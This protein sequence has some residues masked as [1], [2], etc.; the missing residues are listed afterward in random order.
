MDLRDLAH[1]LHH[2]LLGLEILLRHQG[3]A[4]QL[5][6]L[7]QVHLVFQNLRDLANLLLQ[8]I[9]LDLARRLVQ[10]FLGNLLH[11]QGKLSYWDPSWCASFKYH[12]IPFWPSI[13]WREPFVPAGCRIVI[14][15]GV[16]NPPDALA[17]RNN[18]NWRHARPAHWIAEHWC[19]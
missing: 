12:C 6:Q 18:G 9:Q 16:V 5:H 19:E 14:F 15:H 10:Q 1:Q 2:F 4:L 11:Q 3:L 7:L 8:L 13:Y 17:G